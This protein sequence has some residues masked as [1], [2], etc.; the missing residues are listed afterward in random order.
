MKIYLT[1]IQSWQLIYDDVFRNVGV[2]NRFNLSSVAKLCL[3]KVPL[4]TLFA[5]LFPNSVGTLQ[6]LVRKGS[7][8]ET[9]QHS[10]AQIRTHLSKRKL[11]VSS[12]N[13]Y[14]IPWYLH[15]INIYLWDE[16]LLASAFLTYFIR[17]V[18]DSM[19]YLHHTSGNKGFTI[20]A[21]VTKLSISFEKHTYTQRIVVKT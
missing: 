18:W 20:M 6:S 16:L 7:V 21:K 9:P 14:T 1:T 19:S 4:L 15:G 8:W 13:T 17:G 5:I 10:G 3:S 2:I 12:L 11:G